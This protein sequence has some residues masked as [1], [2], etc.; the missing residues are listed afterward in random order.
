VANSKDF[1][2]PD[3]G[4][5]NVR[6]HPKSRSVRVS[7]DAK[8]SIKITIP[9]WL[10]YAAGVEMAN[11]NQVWIRQQLAKRPN[12]IGHGHRIGKSH[13]LSYL[14]STDVTEAKARKKDNQIVV[15]YPENLPEKH[16]TVQKA[17]ETVAVRVLRAEAAKLLPQRLETLATHYGLQYASVSVRQLKTRWGSCDARKHIT[18]NIFLMQL[19]WNLIDYVLVHELAHTEEL[20]HSPRFWDIVEHCMPTAKALRKELKQYQPQVVAATF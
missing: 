19:P 6:K 20:N 13:Y 1:E 4:L 16:H 18:L 9:K 5:I 7:I 14:P 2:L 3:I 17:A 12:Q 8:G 10:P 15:T 11:K